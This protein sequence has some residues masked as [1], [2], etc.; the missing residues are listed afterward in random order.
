MITVFT[1]VSGSGKS[2]LVFGTI[3]AESQR[4]INETYPAF[5]QQF[6][7]H[8]GQPDADQLENISAAIIVDQQRLGGNSRSTVA[9][10]T[11]AAQMLRVLFSRLAEPHL[12]RPGSIP[13]TIRAACAPIAK[14]SAR[15][16]RWTCRAVVD[17]SKSLQEG[18]LLPKGFEVDGWWS[19][20][21]F[22]SG[23]FEPTSRSRTFTPEERDL[24][25]HL[26][27]GRKVKVDKI[28]LTYEGVIAKLKKGLGSKDPE[29]L[30]PHVRARI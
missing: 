16:R 13:T 29:T 17:E 25:F 2:S 6:M 8:Y 3:A 30:Q 23:L 27:D 11:D 9:T 26:D 22:K 14:A 18:A 19:A 12:D 15:S 28:N 21:Y 10:V 4:L 20:V 7:P 1:G 24:L 5:V